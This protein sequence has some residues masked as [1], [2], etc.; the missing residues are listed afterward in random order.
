VQEKSVD[1]TKPSEKP[2]RSSAIPGDDIPEALREGV[3][4]QPLPQQ[5]RAP[6][7][8]RSIGIGAIALGMTSGIG[9][10]L[11]YQF[12]GRISSSQPFQPATTSEQPASL[13]SPTSS[14][15]S[16][17]QAEQTPAL[18]RHLPYQEAPAQTLQPIVADGNVKLR[19]TA[20]QK[21]SEMVQAAGAAGV[22]LQPI[23]GFRSIADQEHVFFD[24]KAERAEGTLERA[25]VSA[26]P[27][28]SEH[29]TGYAIDIGDG[30]RPET[31]L[32]TSFDTTP[33]FQWLQQN[34]AR[35]SFE[36]S[37]PKGNQQGVSYEPW[38]WRFVGDRNSLETF[39]R[40]HTLTGQAGSAPDQAL[41]GQVDS[42]SS[43]GQ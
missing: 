10:F 5:S 16:P 3:A 2:P 43:D 23:S 13:T 1:Q 29:H 11:W 22:F 35:F 14:S 20:A 8:W 33:A 37:F 27:G 31:E 24:V 39:Y 36:M 15:A 42:K 6:L 17:A 19:R 34:A 30:D 7:I 38:H 12:S 32:Q 41:P 40:A 28:Y 9:L 26:P 18:L 25:A 21:F 4:V